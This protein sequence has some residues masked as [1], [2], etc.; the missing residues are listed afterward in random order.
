MTRKFLIALIV[1]LVVVTGFGVYFFFFGD[2]DGTKRP[3]DR[4]RDFFPFGETQDN[5]NEQPS[6]GIT[7]VSPQ[8]GI[9][10]SSNS[11]RIEQ[12]STNPV[13][14]ATFVTKER[15]EEPEN[16]VEFD[17]VDFDRFPVLRQWDNNDQVLDLYNI[18]LL[19][20]ETT[21]EP[22][23][24]FD[25]NLELLV[26]S[27]QEESGL[28]PDGIVGRGTYTKLTEFQNSLLGES[29]LVPA[30]RYIKKENGEVVDI[31]L[32]TKEADVVSNTVVPRVHEAFFG[33]G[34]EQ[35]L[36]RY[37]D[38][39]NETIETFGA[40]IN[41]ERSRLDGI[42]FPKNIPFVALSPDKKEVFY[43]T[44]AGD[45]TKGII[46]S[47]L[48]TNRQPVFEHAFSEW[49]PTW[50]T[51][52]VLELTTRPTF[53]LPGE[54][55][56]IRTSGGDLIRTINNKKGLTVLPSANGEYLLFNET[57]NGNPKLFSKNKN[58]N[59]EK[60]LGVFTQTEK[61][62]FTQQ[63][64]KAYCGVPRTI[65]VGQYPDDWYKGIVSFD[66]TLWVFGLDSDT[67]NRFLVDPEEDRGQE[68]DITKLMLS[69]QED[70]LIFTDKKTGLLYG[71]SI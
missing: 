12:L 26:K 32:D 51:D 71:L 44:E 27:F 30:V 5:Q 50:G 45:Y 34:G 58:T 4:A 33:E 62:V 68:F 18:I 56:S 15:F 17:F 1:L 59:T 37:L 7:D 20:T 55:Y 31:Y 25:G 22:G 10:T 16:A 29:E 64:N 52:S 63:S 47:L 19:T 61:C 49:I 46:S 57:V 66:D 6:D 8:P 28:T 42:F 54:N 38:T 11:S 14:G 70:Y 3:V 39:D 67:P 53:A 9:P 23:T 41:Q 40:T 2:Q 13:A 36:L 43:L 21:T 65:P 24:L 35:V 48:N 60:D 69:P